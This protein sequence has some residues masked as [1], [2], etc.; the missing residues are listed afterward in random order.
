VLEFST[1]GFQ[2]HTE[3]LHAVVEAT[4]KGS[5]DSIHLAI[6]FSNH[7][8]ALLKVTL[9]TRSDHTEVRREPVPSL[10]F[11]KKGIQ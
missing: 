1:D 11:Q 9:D 7:L 10:K 6:R 4:R 2:K 5:P 8:A 3:L